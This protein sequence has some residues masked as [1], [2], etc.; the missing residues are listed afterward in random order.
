VDKKPSV[1][2]FDKHITHVGH[3]GVFQ[4]VGFSPGLLIVDMAGNAAFHLPFGLESEL[5]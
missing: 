5:L 4:P 2:D 3:S 1:T